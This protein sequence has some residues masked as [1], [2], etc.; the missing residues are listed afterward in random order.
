MKK[1]ITMTAFVLLTTGTLAGCSKTGNEQTKQDSTQTTQ[2]APL[3]NED[4]LKESIKNFLPAEAKNIQFTSQFD[5][6]VGLLGINS[7]FSTSGDLQIDD[8]G[9]IKISASQKENEKVLEQSAEYYQK[10]GSSYKKYVEQNGTKVAAQFNNGNNN[11]NND[12]YTLDFIKFLFGNVDNLVNNINNKKFEEKDGELI[13][14]G[15]I[16]GQQILN[17]Y[18]FNTFN[19]LGD[20]AG[21][22][23]F[24]AQDLPLT[25]KIDKNNKEIKT[26]EL[27]FVE[28][29][30]EVLRQGIA[31]DG[32]KIP[33][34]MISSANLDAKMVFTKTKGAVSPIQLP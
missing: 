14:T 33:E 22:K 32:E 29:F 11:D 8:K 20:D 5:V 31:T 34:E 3:S 16:K 30:K 6:K 25:V 2:T 10:D 9:N 28:F 1:I 17:G 4:V 7:S 23:I 27:N 21:M 13:L 18:T 12:L 24:L 26:I 19:F 15:T